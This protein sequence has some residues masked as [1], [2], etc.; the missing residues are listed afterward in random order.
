[1]V[2]VCYCTQLCV[3][4]TIS[5]ESKYLKKKKTLVFCTKIYLLDTHLNCL[6]QA[7]LV[8]IL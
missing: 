4:Q 7:S 3:S 6:N 8:G 2:N 1:M 5:K